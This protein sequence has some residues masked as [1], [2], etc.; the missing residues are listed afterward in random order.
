MHVRSDKLKNH[1][2]NI[3]YSPI[4][5][6][7]SIFQLNQ[8][9]EVNSK[10]LIPNNRSPIKNVKIVN[11]AR[12]DQRTKEIS[13]LVSYRWIEITHVAASPCK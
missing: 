4:I 8:L 6:F 7:S 5:F 10:N 9:I 12:S 11:R 13:K 3:N 2:Q 1:Y